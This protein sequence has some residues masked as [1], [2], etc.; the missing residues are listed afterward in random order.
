MELRKN[1]IKEH[2]V[3][4]GFTCSLT[5]SCLYF[6]KENTFLLIYED[7]LILLFAC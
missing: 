6:D 1:T 7:D 3:S 4:I 5:D 2:L